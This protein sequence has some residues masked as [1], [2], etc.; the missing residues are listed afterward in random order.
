MEAGALNTAGL[1]INAGAFPTT[2]GKVYTTAD[3][4]DATIAADVST[5]V[6]E[7]SAMIYQL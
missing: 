1:Q 4:I 6:F 5:C 2:N 7:V 3:T